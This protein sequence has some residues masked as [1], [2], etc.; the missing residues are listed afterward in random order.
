MDISKIGARKFTEAS[1]RREITSQLASQFDSLGIVSPL[2]LGG[3][4]ILQ[5]VATSGTD[6]D[7]VLPDG[8][9]KQ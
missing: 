8:I 6:W 5:K 4:L 3:K 1:T 9:K 7:K 2:L